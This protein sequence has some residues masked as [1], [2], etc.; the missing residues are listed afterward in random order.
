MQSF[1]DKMAFRLPDFMSSSTTSAG[2]KGNSQRPQP[3]KV[4]RS[5]SRPEPSSPDRSRPLRAHTIQ[6][7]TIKEGAAAD[8]TSA[9][10]PKM[11]QP[12]VFEKTPVDADGQKLGEE[13][14]GKH[15]IDIHEL[16]IELAS[17]SDR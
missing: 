7:G 8:T 16:P 4:S 12:D 17:L 15:H 3:L 6:N 10:N 13:A 11:S 5:F 2:R 14:S 1:T 9:S